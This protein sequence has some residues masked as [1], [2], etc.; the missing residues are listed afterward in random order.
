MGQLSEAEAQKLWLEVT[1]YAQS[2]LSVEQARAKSTNTASPDDEMKHIQA[3]T[4]SAH[5]RDVLRR[6]IGS[7]IKEEET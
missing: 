7:H 4:Y 6:I 5:R 3:Q 2:I 1:A